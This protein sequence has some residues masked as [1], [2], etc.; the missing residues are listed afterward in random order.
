MAIAQALSTF[1]HLDPSNPETVFGPDVLAMLTVIGVSIVGAADALA[2][3]VAPGTLRQYHGQWKKFTRWFVEASACAGWPT[4]VRITDDDVIFVYGLSMLSRGLRLSAFNLFISATSYYRGFLDLPSVALLP[5]FVKLRQAFKRGCG[6]FHMALPTKKQLADLA[7]S[8]V[9]EAWRYTDFQIRALFAYFVGAGFCLRTG[10]IWLIRSDYIDVLKKT[11]TF[12]RHLLGNGL[13]SGPIREFS[14][15]QAQEMLHALFLFN[16]RNI[17]VGWGRGPI[18]TYS[19]GGAQCHP[20]G[21]QA[22]WGKP[23]LLED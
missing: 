22:P 19:E 4:N 11:V 8:L 21:C 16:G 7:T 13:K 6:G 2:R 18:N 15:G 14:M 23:E 10:E 9:R 5:R 17:F 12:P 20:A 1:D 3:S